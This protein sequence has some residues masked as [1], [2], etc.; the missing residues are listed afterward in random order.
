MSEQQKHIFDKSSCLTKKQFK[1]YLSGGMAQ[2]ECHVAEHHINACF[3]CS[4]A[5]D[6]GFDNKE[7]ALSAIQEINSNFLREHLSLSDPKIYLNS[8]APT[9]NHI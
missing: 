4:E 3:L 7:E 2:E 1:E 8:L 6:G 9:V 5:I